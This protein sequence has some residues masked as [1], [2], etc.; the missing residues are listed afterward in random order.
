MENFKHTKGK[1]IYDY[2]TK[3]LVKEDGNIVPLPNNFSSYPKPEEE[4]FNH[5]PEWHEA[6][7]NIKLIECVPQMLDLLIKCE[8]E[9][10]ELKEQMLKP[11]KERSSF[12]IS[13]F[14]KSS[15]GGAELSRKINTLINKIT[16]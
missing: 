11:S 15:I 16:K 7:A 14:L 9:L 1:W 13:D 2:K 8:R 5:L 4:I 10:N 12:W 6:Q 3:Q